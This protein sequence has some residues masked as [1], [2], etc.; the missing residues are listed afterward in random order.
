MSRQRYKLNFDDL[1]DTS[2]FTAANADAIVNGLN[3]N[4]SVALL[5][6]VGGTGSIDYEDG[7]TIVYDAA[8]KKL[9]SSG[10]GP[11]SIDAY[12]KTEMDALMAGKSTGRFNI[13][14]TN[15]INKPAT[16]GSRI[17]YLAAPIQVV[18]QLRHTTAHGTVT[19]I[20]LTAGG[21]S[22]SSNFQLA[23]SGGGGTGL[24]AKATA[25]AGIVTRITIT[26]P[27]TGYTSAPTASFA[28]GSG[29]G[30]TATV[31]LGATSIAAVTITNRGSNYPNVAIPVSFSGGGGSG[32]TG[33]ATVNGVVS[34]ITSLVGGSAY[35]SAPLVVISGDGT[36]AS[37]LAT[38]SGGAV[39]AINITNGGHGYSNA[40]IDLIPVGA[41]SGASAVVV[42]AQ[43]IDSVTIDSPGSG[44]TSS[45]T[46]VFNLGSGAAATS[47][48]ASGAVTAVNVTNGGGQYVVAPTVT[49]TGGGGTGAT[50][51]AVLTS[52]VVT[53][54]NI[55]NGGS[56][57]TTPASVAFSVP[58]SG[59]AGRGVGDTWVHYVF[60]GSSNIPN[61]ATHLILQC[62][63]QLGAQDGSLTT[64]VSASAGG[65]DIILAQC[66]AAGGDGSGATVGVGTTGMCP[67]NQSDQSFQ[68]NLSNSGGFVYCTM[69]LYILGYIVQ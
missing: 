8:T 3:N 55:T 34:G 18:G 19:N 30:A 6:K 58:G 5:V 7:Q 39:T 69:S 16:L 63:T 59:A 51:T 25:V 62:F 56:G 15:V 47:S 31:V 1:V 40:T 52:G 27:G 35:A 10:S 66:A 20:L 29:S 14:W 28:A 22:Y 61:N 32:A 23:F 42:L 33:T 65:I 48:V 17:S 50:A 26:N 38:V 49:L 21:S 53:S 46:A 4:S 44:Y 54:V 24:T 13:D 68:Y 60:P 9:K 43:G 11:N 67:I 45:P 64:S 36:G 41:G 2:F 12:S 37:A 57:Y